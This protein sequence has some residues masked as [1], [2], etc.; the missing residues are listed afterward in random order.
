MAIF[1]VEDEPPT[2]PSSEQ[3]EDQVEMLADLL[4]ASYRAVQDSEVP[5]VDLLAAI[6]D[7]FAALG[8]E[9]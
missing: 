3:L 8:L 6:E 1:I 4:R 5:E 7:L 2:G 9:L